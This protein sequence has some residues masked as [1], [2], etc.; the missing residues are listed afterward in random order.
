MAED[1]NM[2]FQMDEFYFTI[3][4]EDGEEAELCKDGRTRRV[5]A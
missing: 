5:T 4:K 2:D 1:P 3:M